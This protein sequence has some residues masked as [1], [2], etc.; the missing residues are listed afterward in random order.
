MPEYPGGT[1]ALMKYLQESFFY[2]APAYQYEIERRFVCKFIV[3]AEGDVVYVK[4]VRGISPEFDRDAMYY[5][6]NMP[7]W[8]PGTK[9][10]KNVNVYYKL[11]FKLKKIIDYPAGVTE[12][13]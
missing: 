9:K 4:V 5:I 6:L 3:T 12:T 10:D 7:D 2:R 13:K 8:T 11:S 1:E